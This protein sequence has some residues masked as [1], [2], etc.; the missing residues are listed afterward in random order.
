MGDGHTP[1]TVC[2]DGTIPYV[3]TVAY[4]GVPLGTR[5]RINKKIYTVHDRTLYDGVVDIY[6]NSIEECLEYGVKYKEIEIV[7]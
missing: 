3:G 7:N 2:A 1:S 5:I 4:N 6:M